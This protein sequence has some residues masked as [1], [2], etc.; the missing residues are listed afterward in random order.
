MRLETEWR[1]DSAHFSLIAMTGYRLDTSGLDVPQVQQLP[2]RRHQ[3]LEGQCQKYQHHLTAQCD[4]VDSCRA[5]S[6]LSPPHRGCVSASSRKMLAFD[7]SSLSQISSV[8]TNHNQ[9]VFTACRYH[10]QPQCIQWLTCRVFQKLGSYYLKIYYYNNYYKSKDYSDTVIK[11]AGALD[12]VSIK[13]CRTVHKDV[14]Q[15]QSVVNSRVTDGSDKTS[16]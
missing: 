3:L 4:L 7:L 2:V 10:G 1:H 11:V 6:S 15:T 13:M 12:N 5:V 9:W 8:T 14:T 16:F